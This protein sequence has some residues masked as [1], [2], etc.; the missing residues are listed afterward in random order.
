MTV[1]VRRVTLSPSADEML[2]AEAA[3]AKM[4]PEI[5][6][7]LLLELAVRERDE[8]A[9]KFAAAAAAVDGQLGS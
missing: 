2:V 6:G 8:L 3:R 9:K 5:L 7:S 4:A 1:S